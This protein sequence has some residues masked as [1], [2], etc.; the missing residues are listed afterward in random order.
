MA[1]RRK[2][3]PAPLFDEIVFS[4]DREMVPGSRRVVSFDQQDEED[5]LKAIE[6]VA[7]LKVQLRRRDHDHGAWAELDLTASG[8]N[9]LR[10]APDPALL[11][12]RWNAARPILLPGLFADIP[13]E[14]GDEGL[15]LGARL[16]EPDGLKR[17]LES[18]R[19]LLPAEFGLLSRGHS[20]D[21]RCIEKRAFK[22]TGETAPWLMSTRLSDSPDDASVRLRVSFGREVEDDA[23][24]DQ[25][26]HLTV[27]RLAE[28][29]L[30]G[31]LR[32]DLDR[33]LLGKVNDL[34][35]GETYLTQHIGYW[36]APN[37]GALMHHDAF[38]EPDNGGQRGVV[39]TQLAGTTAWLALSIE[40]LA[41]R[42]VDY[43]EF[44]DQGGAEWVRKAIWPDRRDFER[45]MARTHNRRA[46]LKE[47]A[48]PGC[49]KF[50]GLVNLGPDFTSFLADAG[51]AFFLR[52]GDSLLMPS[53]GLDRCLM[54][55][56]FCA[57]DT[58]TYAIS[59]ALRT[60]STVLDATAG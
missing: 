29:L 57:S 16:T 15:A 41:D 60:R 39:Y 3:T 54:H 24:S 42:L 34:T 30:P 49:G 56:V 28:S 52:A 44:L 51:H 25:E 13:T 9:P 5:Y 19:G 50:A 27:T 55:S 33:E 10:H 2:D 48:L 18:Q 11:A 31:A 59:A 53:H 6:E 14:I 38:D 23:S 22:H 1:S 35:E 37:G 12:E 32:I 21:P 58:P 43:C 8:I 46:F 47:L 20:D 7:S 36:N 45:A 4:P 26:A 17:W 40:D